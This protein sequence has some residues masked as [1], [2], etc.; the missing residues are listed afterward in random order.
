MKKLISIGVAL[1]LLAMVVLPVG[2]AADIQP[3][4]YAKIP[5]AIIGSF[6]EMIGDILGLADPILTGMNVS[7]PFALA[8]AVPILNVIGNWTAGPLAWSVDML[9]WGI[10]LF[11][12]VYGA[13]DTMF[14]IGYANLTDI[15]DTMACGLRQCWQGGCFNITW[16]CS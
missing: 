15:L 4:S 16:N 1:A 5:F 11:A 12:D 7:L 13:L 3:T 10:A 9:A 6:F 2:V 8:D 14:G